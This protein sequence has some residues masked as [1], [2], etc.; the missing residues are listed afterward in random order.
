MRW[1]VLRRLPALVAACALTACGSSTAHT[2]EPSADATIPSMARGPIS[3]AV[4][5]TGGS[6][7]SATLSARL[8]AVDSLPSG[9]TVEIATSIDGAQRAVADLRTFIGRCPT[10]VSSG[11]SW[12]FAVTPGPQVGDDSLHLSCSM[13]S[14]TDTLGCDSVLVRIGTTL[15][16]VRAQAANPG[17]RYLQ[18]VA[19]AALRRYQVTGP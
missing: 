13:T 8:V 17:D 16:V 7:Y 9:F 14:G 11:L 15:V 3:P 2:A 1:M 18:Q 12:R 6:G 5:A 4:P 10:V 19:E